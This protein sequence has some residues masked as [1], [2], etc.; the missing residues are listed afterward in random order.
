[1]GPQM[2]LDPKW[3]PLSAA[4]DPVKSRGMEWILGTDGELE[5]RVK[6]WNELKRYIDH[7]ASYGNSFSILFSNDVSCCEKLRQEGSS[8]RK[9]AFYFK[10][11]KNGHMTPRR[12]IVCMSH[13]A[14]NQHRTYLWRYVFWMRFPYIVEPVR[15]TQKGSRRRFAEV[16]SWGKITP[17]R[18]KLLDNNFLF[19]INRMFNFYSYFSFS[20]S[21]V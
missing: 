2:I 1:M 15:Y 20:K 21:F 10:T 5:Q 12:L 16:T 19:H 13:T 9:L 8:S 4:N 17:V 6:Q 14:S 3:S 7:S 18:C 11:E